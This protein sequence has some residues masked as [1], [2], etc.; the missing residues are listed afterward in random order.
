MFFRS[1]QAIFLRILNIGRKHKAHRQ[2]LAQEKPWRKS[3]KGRR[4]DKGKGKGRR[5]KMG[6]EESSIVG[7]DTPPLTLTSRTLEALARYIRDGHAKQI[8]VMVWTKQ[9]NP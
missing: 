3:E 6:N 4:D 7:E 5:S 1:L 9:N 8:V 2:Q